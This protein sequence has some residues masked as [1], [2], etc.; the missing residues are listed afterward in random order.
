MLNFVVAAESC[1][2]PSGTEVGPSAWGNA[3]PSHANAVLKSGR[4][5][6][7]GKRQ[8]CGDLDVAEVQITPDSLITTVD[9]E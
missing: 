2:I 5:P 9:N 7:K 8:R 1:Q 3:R 6:N 4:D